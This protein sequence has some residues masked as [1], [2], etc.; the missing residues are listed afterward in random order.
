MKAFCQWCWAPIKVPDTFDTT[1]QVAVCDSK[2]WWAETLFRR[3]YSD[4]EVTMRH[5]WNKEN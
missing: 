2:C 4:E 3:Y 5:Y 1:K